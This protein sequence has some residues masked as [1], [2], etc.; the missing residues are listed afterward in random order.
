MFARQMQRE[1]GLPELLDL[2]PA[3]LEALH[4]EGGDYEWDGDSGR[5]PG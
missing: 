2:H 4:L 1:N 5:E 3:G